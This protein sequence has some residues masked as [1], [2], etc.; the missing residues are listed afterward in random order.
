MEGKEKVW[1]LLGQVVTI[2]QR[3]Q[4]VPWKVIQESV[5]EVEEED[6]KLGLKDLS[7]LDLPKGEAIGK[8]FLQLFSTRWQDRLDKMN[9]AIEKQ[10]ST[11]KRQ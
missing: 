9:A 10:N 1:Q 8:I 11:E 6:L 7:V 4:T 3:K 5:A 2:H